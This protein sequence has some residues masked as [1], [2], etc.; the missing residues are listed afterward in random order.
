MKGTFR[1]AATGIANF[2]LLIMNEEKKKNLD[3]KS[4]S[5]IERKGWYILSKRVK[6]KIIKE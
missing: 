4:E 3:Q 6:R 1:S 5:K 2:T